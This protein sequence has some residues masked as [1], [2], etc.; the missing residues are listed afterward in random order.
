[1]K[2]S[3]VIHFCPNFWLRLHIARALNIIIFQ[4]ILCFSPHPHDS[5]DVIVTG[6]AQLAVYH[7]VHYPFAVSNHGPSLY[8][9]PG[10]SPR[11]SCNSWSPPMMASS[12]STSWLRGNLRKKYI[13]SLDNRK[14]S[15]N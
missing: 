7:Q 5:D 6:V 8:S 1:M 12:C 13:D 9:S 15:E 2:Y 3:T 11:H 10:R 4:P 14:P